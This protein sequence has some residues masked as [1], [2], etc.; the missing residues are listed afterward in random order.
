MFNFFKRNKRKKTKIV[1]EIDV[2]EFLD[3]KESFILVMLMSGC[4]ACQMQKPLIDDLVNN[5]EVKMLVV[6]MDISTSPQIQERYRI[7]SVPT[8]LGFSKGERVFQQS[9][10]MT[11]GQLRTLVKNLEENHG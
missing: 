10:I 6:G 8:T 2:L 7:R 4:G 11:R 5:Q 9:G 1:S 3:Q